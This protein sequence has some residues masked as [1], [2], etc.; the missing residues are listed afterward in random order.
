MLRHNDYGLAAFTTPGESP[1]RYRQDNGK[2]SH[3]HENVA[4]IEERTL[5]PGR[6]INPYATPWGANIRPTSAEGREIP[7]ASNSRGPR[8]AC[9]SSWPAIR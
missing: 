7:Q 3:G 5:Q 8:Y 2:V 9:W 4:V 6:A 1:L